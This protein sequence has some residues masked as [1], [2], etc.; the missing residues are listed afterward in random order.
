[1]HDGKLT[2]SLLI[3]AAGLFVTSLI[4]GSAA[5]RDDRRGS[6]AFFAASIASAIAAVWCA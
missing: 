2:A 3:V 1:M 5:Y 4:R 6:W